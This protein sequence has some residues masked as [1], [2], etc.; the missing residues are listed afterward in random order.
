MASAPVALSASGGVLVGGSTL[1]VPTSVAVP[2]VAATA[3]L[4]HGVW[5][6]RLALALRKNDS[7]RAART[8]AILAAALVLGAVSS[9]A[10]M[11]ARPAGVVAVGLA[12]AGAGTL[13]LAGLLRL[14]GVATDGPAGLR[15]G[16][17]GLCVALWKFL[18]IWILVLEPR[19]GL[20][21]LAFTTSLLACI[22]LTIAVVSGVRA[23]YPRSSTLLAAGGSAAV[24]FALAV[25]TLVPAPG[26]TRDGWLLGAGALLV[27]G[28][29]LTWAGASRA[30][31]EPGFGRPSPKITDD[32]L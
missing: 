32:T 3:G 15:R 21:P 4:L 20:G 19:G 25:L 31:V 2:A 11:I 13:L 9:V 26:P 18:V 16:L 30:V 8:S 24:V 12:A 23:R 29:V 5:L 22:G 7:R 14:P 1:G 6:L 17:D 27:L 10:I 28:P